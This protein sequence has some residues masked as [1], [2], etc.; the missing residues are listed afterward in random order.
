[1]PLPVGAK[2]E[3][4]VLPGNPYDYWNPVTATHFIGREQELMRAYQA[5]EEQHSISLVGDHLIGK[6]SFLNALENLY[7]GQGRKVVKL[8]GLGHESRSVQHFVEA[9]TGISS[10][11]EADRAAN[12]LAHWAAQNTQGQQAPLLLIDDAEGCFQRFPLRFFERLRGMLY[13]LVLVFAS[14][15]DLDLI[16]ADNHP[17]ETVSPLEARLEIIRLGLLDENAAAIIWQ[18]GVGVMERQDEEILSLWAGR[19]PYYLKLFGANLW[20]ARKKQ[21]AIETVLDQ[22]YDDTRRHLRQ[23]WNSLTTT[24]Q[25]ILKNSLDGRA[26]KR[27]SLRLRGLVTDSGQLF[28]QVLREWLEQEL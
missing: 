14:S 10:E 17:V 3:A 18:L 8:S 11:N 9:I 19:H 22:V 4:I 6:S 15:Q 20:Q 12:V 25:Q 13:K 2:A 24:E 1:M 26:V 21:I 7:S 23:I 16:K 28:G 27:R 5:I